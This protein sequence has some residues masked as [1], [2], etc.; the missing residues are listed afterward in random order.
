MRDRYQAKRD[1]VD[2]HK[3]SVGCVDC[4]YNA[5]PAA[6]QYDHVVPGGKGTDVSL[7]VSSGATIQEIMAEI[8]KCEVVCAN[9]HAIRTHG[10]GYPGVG[11]RYKR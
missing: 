3:L 1:A 2:A 9:C 10:R 8:E 4:G 5:H 6:L 11:R 7:L